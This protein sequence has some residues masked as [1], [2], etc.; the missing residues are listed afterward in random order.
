MKRIK[1]KISS[2]T[3]TDQ[4]L[5]FFFFIFLLLLFL[6]VIFIPIFLFCPSCQE[7]PTEVPGCRLRQVA[8]MPQTVRSWL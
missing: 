6:I 8:Q 2:E 7:I 1:S 5:L 3:K 4:D